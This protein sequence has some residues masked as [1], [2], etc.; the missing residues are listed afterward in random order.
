MTLCATTDT[1]FNSGELF[2]A[3]P[4][5]DT[6]VASAVHNGATPDAVVAAPT[7]ATIKK[8]GAAGNPCANDAEA[9]DAN[10]AI[11]RESM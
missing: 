5:N 10:D 1:T 4:N 7:P 6:L 2:P 8:S 3:E 9:F 11:V